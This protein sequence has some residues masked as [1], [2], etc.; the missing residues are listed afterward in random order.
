M[1]ELRAELRP[2]W[3]HGSL[4]CGRVRGYAR[5]DVSGMVLGV[6][7]VFKVCLVTVRMVTAVLGSLGIR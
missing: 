6:T 2:R 7:I 1:S 3:G 5:P 4:G